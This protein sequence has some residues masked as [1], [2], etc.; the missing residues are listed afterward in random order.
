ME[1]EINEITNQIGIIFSEHVKA[2]EAVTL[3]AHQT[4]VSG[5][6]KL[7]KECLENTANLI[8]ACS[9]FYK[10]AM[11]EIN[12]QQETAAKMYKI[13]QTLTE[14]AST[15]SP[16]ELNAK[17]KKIQEEMETQLEEI[18]SSLNKELASIN[19]TDPKLIQ[20]LIEHM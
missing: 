14:G 8:E 20:K 16:S 4:V 15:D 12:S 6:N 7:V 1:G 2:T 19:N 11:K 5:Y 17:A 9:T 18:I 10:H 3:K 13:I